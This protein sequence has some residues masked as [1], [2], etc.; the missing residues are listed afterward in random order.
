V[1]LV[2]GAVVPFLRGFDSTLLGVSVLLDLVQVIEDLQHG[3]GVLRKLLWIH[4]SLDGLTAFLLVVLPEDEVVRPG[5]G[6]FVPLRELVPGGHLVAVEL[7]SPLFFIPTIPTSFGLFRILTRL[8]GRL[9][10][11]IAAII[12]SICH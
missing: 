9:E 6:V 7:P 1:V 2:T 5:E 12:P 3:L 4:A 10:A 8:Y 11:E